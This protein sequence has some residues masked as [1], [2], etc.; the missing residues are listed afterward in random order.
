MLALA[1]TGARYAS[2]ALALWG[3]GVVASQTASSPAAAGSPTGATTSAFSLQDQEKLLQSGEIVASKE[4]A[5][6]TTKTLRVTLSDG[7]RQH[8]AHIQPIDI[9]KPVWRGKGGTVEKDFKDTWKFNVAAYKIDR[10]LG[11][12][13]VPVTVQRDYMGK[14]ASWTWWADNVQMTEL[15]RR[16]R[17]IDPPMTERWVNQLQTVRVFDQLIYN[18][19]RNQGNLLITD[20]WDVIMIDHTRAF[21]TGP[22]LQNTRVLTRINADLLKALRGLQR[23][24][25]DRELAP[26]LTPAEI[27]GVLARRDRI[28]TFFQ[29]E[30]SQK[31]EEAVL[32]G[33]PRATPKVSVP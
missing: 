18:T 12:N 11:L 31:G 15:Q 24:V 16:D 9:Y 19:D 21:R 2:L 23:N 4:L 8:D 7:K 5:E 22:E 28:V 10:L 33:L 29:N 13:M 30:I 26:Y 20:K 14:P 6:G 3:V 32:T 17:K 1:K 25:L 27:S